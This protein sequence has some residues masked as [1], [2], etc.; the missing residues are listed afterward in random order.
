MEQLN[1]FNIEENFP[2]P[3]P[4][5]VRRVEQLAIDAVR[6]YGHKVR[7]VKWKNNR[8]VMASVGKGGVLNIHTIYKRANK[9]DLNNLAVV[10][11]GRAK[12]KDIEQFQKYIRHYLPREIGEGK[13]RL[14]INPARGLFHDLNQKF[15]RVLPLLGKPLKTVP[16]LGWSPVRVGK[17]GITWGTQRES[18]G[19]P[20]ILVNAVLDAQ[21]IP[22]FVVEHI[23]WHEL[24]HQVVPPENGNGNSNKRVVHGKAFR[25][26]ESR[27]PRLNAAE[28]WEQKNVGKLIRK[29]KG[30]RG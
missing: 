4:V 12:P 19:E 10:M 22:N 28:E 17:N 27:Y 6:S 2:E 1:L 15:A 20:L 18:E 9:S 30:R 11:S 3:D 24:C 13:S 16:K 25:E 5:R 7:S 26:M 23:L 8:R 29:H 21:D 14:I